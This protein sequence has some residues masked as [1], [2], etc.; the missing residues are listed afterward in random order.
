MPK[1]PRTFEI[2]SL[3]QRYLKND[4]KSLIENLKIEELESAVIDLGKTDFDAPY[5]LAMEER[6]NELIQEKFD[7]EIKRKHR[8]NLMIPILI[9]ILLT[10]ISGFYF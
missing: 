4:D 6:I 2:M 5:R 3:F 7:T 1:K 9:A 10:L 8:Q